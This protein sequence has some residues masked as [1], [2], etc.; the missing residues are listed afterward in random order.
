[1]APH[2]QGPS[3]DTARPVSGKSV[4]CRVSCARSLLCDYTNIPY[5][6]LQVA[7]GFLLLILRFSL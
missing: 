6:S 5:T 1:M 4:F 3:D 2:Y 7:S